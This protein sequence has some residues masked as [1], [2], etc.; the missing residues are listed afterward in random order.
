[1]AV[2]P[3]TNVQCLNDTTWQQSTQIVTTMAFYKR[4]ANTFYSRSNGT[5]LGI[6]DLSQASSQTISPAE[7]FLVLDRFFNVPDESGN[8]STTTQDFIRWVN[9]YL[10]AY[11]LTA[12]PGELLDTQNFLR[13][14]LTLPL[15]WFQ[16]NSES[17]VV[18][19]HSDS[20]TS[21]LPS[22]L[23]VTASLSQSESR[24]VI[25]RWT[26]IVFMSVGLVVYAWCIAWLA[27]TMTIQGPNISFF[28]LLDFAS[29]VASSESLLGED[30][31][32]LASTSRNSD[33]KEQ[34]QDVK[35]YLRVTRRDPGVAQAGSDGEV[36]RIGFSTSV[37][38]RLRRGGSY[39]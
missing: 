22:N 1:M 9:T 4:T 26:T 28:P 10:N 8:Q 37:A 11:L 32:R 14:L 39:Y 5:L 38:G 29:R 25:S 16:S 31:A 30:F 34:L 17:N 20:L 36:S 3:N 13:S 24:I 33:I 15:I 7:L 19:P 35:I 23:Y 21:N 2:C 6:A 12:S 18:A 27:W